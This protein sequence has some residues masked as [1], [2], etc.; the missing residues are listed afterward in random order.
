[1]RTDYIGHD[2]A[3]QRKRD[4]PDYAGWIRR[5]ELAEDWKSSWQPLVQESVF[6]EQGRLLELGC[7]AGNL[8]IYFA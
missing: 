4:D 6:P 8:G 2:R 5:D 1:M 3:Y 7:G